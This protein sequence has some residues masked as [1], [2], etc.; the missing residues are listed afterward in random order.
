V[1][2]YRYAE[3]E[4]AEPGSSE[5]LGGVDRD[6]AVTAGQTKQPVNLTHPGPGEAQ[7]NTAGYVVSRYGK[8]SASDLIKLTHVED[9]WLTAN[10]GR[11]PKTSRRIEHEWMRDYFRQNAAG[12]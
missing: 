9:P 2:E 11:R 1:G 4:G 10:Q 12:R 8:M 5:A 6:V 7:L 3:N